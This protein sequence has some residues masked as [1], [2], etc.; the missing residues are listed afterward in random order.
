MVKPAYD[1]TASAASA[2]GAVAV[3]A[4]TTKKK[5]KRKKK[6]KNRKRKDEARRKRERWRQRRLMR[7][8]GNSWLIRNAPFFTVSLGCTIALIVF[9]IVWYI[10]RQ[11]E[12]KYLRG[13][14]AVRP[15]D[16]VFQ[17][18]RNDEVYKAKRGLFWPWLKGLFGLESD[19][20]AR[21]WQP[22][23]RTRPCNP[24]HFRCMD[25]MVGV[26]SRRDGHEVRQVIR[27][28]WAS[29]HDN[30]FFVL[31]ACCRIPLHERSKYKC[32]RAK[33]RPFDPA[34]QAR[35]DAVCAR[36]DARIAA[37]ADKYDDII[38]MA[39]T[40]VYRHLPQKVKYL[41]KWGLEHT[42][43]KWFVKTDDDSVVRIDTLGHYLANTYDA[44]ELIVLGNIRRG[45]RVPRRGKWAEPHYHHSRY[46][47][48]PFGPNGHAVSQ[49]VAE[50]IVEHTDML[51]N[52][53]GEDVS[54]GIW[55]DESPI[56][57]EITWVSSKHVSHFGD[58]KNPNLFMIGHQIKPS[59]I[60]QCFQKGDEHLARVHIPT[61]HTV[62]RI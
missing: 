9:N 14:H 11:R 22:Q 30:V 26:L 16:E 33:N 46:P 31:G 25:I 38:T 24:P 23:A 51:F 12:A 39:E 48:F 36:Q 53:Q 27:E 35:Q 42:T 56:S 6:S 52:Y 1:S 37:E 21:Q 47:P 49:G 2:T 17:I 61:K 55:L 3:P 5:I 59:K 44:D 41:Y 40:D 57:L 19:T 50:Y 4:S 32:E 7:K 45:L 34:T 43:A 8:P 15:Q 60:R 13:V 10:G 54:I 20:N 29:G 28:T 58:C 62:P 18:I